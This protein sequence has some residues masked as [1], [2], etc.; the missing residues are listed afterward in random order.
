[1]NIGQSKSSFYRQKVILIISISILFLIFIKFF[2]ITIIQ[3]DRLKTSSYAN[4]LRKI[5][6]NA[7]RGIIY[8]R[9]KVPIVDNRPTY[10]LKLT[11]FDVTD[12]FNYNLLSKL[13]QIDKDT[14][15]N[16]IS[17]SKKKFKVFDPILLKRHVDFKDISK[18]QEYKLEFPGLFFS[19]FPSRTYPSNAN[20]THI[21][22]YLREVSD[23]MLKT[24]PC[25]SKYKLGDVY[26]FTGIEK[27]YECDLRGVDGIDYHLYDV[28]GLDHG[29]YDFDENYPI[30][31]G[32][33]L[34]LTIDIGLQEYSESLMKNKKGSII[35][36]DPRSGDIL[37]MVSSPDYNLQSFTG[38]IPSTL[39]NSW[40][41]DLD[42][43]LINRAI[44][45]LYPPGSVL[46]LI[47]AAYAIDNNIVSKDWEV[48]CN[49]IYDF[50]NQQYSCWNEDGHGPTNLVESIK[51]SC[52]V[53]YY[54]LISKINIDDWFLMAKSFGFNRM[55]NI[56][57]PSEFSG[58]IPDRKYMNDKYGK[59]GWAQG[60]L[61]NFVIGQGDVLATPL[62]VLQMI[63]LIATNGSTFEPHLRLNKEKIPVKL[64]LKKTTWDIVNKA[65][66]DA[67]NSSGGTGW[68]ANK[69][70]NKIWGKT[71]TSQN[72]HGEDHSWF[73]GYTKIDNNIM[74]LTVI[75]ENGGKGSGQGSII[76][77]KLF[78]YYKAMDV[79][80]ENN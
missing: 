23:K 68:R 32:E 39:W 29:I 3:H 18:I 78:E 6:H 15:E 55:S 49:G 20:A 76:A 52:N 47:M 25:N 66:W 67:V 27:V 40:N 59:H 58:I 34:F 35:A 69:S 11:P 70:G 73:S 48:D 16:K 10:D 26:G 64:D 7:P 56:D 74:S 8:D 13:I 30:V 53:Y 22:G 41:S 51:H 12:R 77:G 17:R 79:V 14:L 65:M 21:L 62:Q 36:M 60:H 1:M 72:P 31:N 45:G 54:E 19:E 42:K 37:A 24:D 5:Y 57:L 2:D 63:N 28:K 38:P 75:V 43:P 4:S 71:G 33:D 50:Y 44:Q 61:L 9:N 80:N 46:K